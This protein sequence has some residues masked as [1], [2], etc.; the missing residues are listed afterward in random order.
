MLEPGD[1]APRYARAF[2]PEGL[3][4]G[5][6]H[7][8]PP[9][10]HRNPYRDAIRYEV[11]GLAQRHKAGVTTVSRYPSLGADH[12]DPYLEWLGWPAK[13][14]VAS[15][16]GG[17]PGGGGAGK[18]SPPGPVGSS[19][20]AQSLSHPGTRRLATT[21]VGATALSWRP[22]P[23]PAPRQAHP[24]PAPSAADIYDIISPA[25]DVMSRSYP[26]SIR[27]TIQLHYPRRGV[28]GSISVTAI[29]SGQR[30]TL[31]IRPRQH[32]CGGSATPAIMFR[33]PVTRLCSWPRKRV[34]P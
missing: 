8:S 2:R 29:S 4:V 9:L 22:L 31:L 27:L 21:G 7:P 13:P 12:P 26:P 28:G 6:E 10:R 3:E 20:P 11:T 30:R 32:R 25:S 19:A 1:S 15:A 18:P 33:K 34:L 16:A 17:W 24:P 5:T 23:R 14:M